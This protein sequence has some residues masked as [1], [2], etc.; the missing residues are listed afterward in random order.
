MAN[1]FNGNKELI[2]TIDFLNTEEEK[3][4]NQLLTEN[5]E[6]RFQIKQ[7]E[8]IGPKL[9]NELK[10]NARNAIL[11]S[12]LLIGLYITIRFDSFYALGSLV[13]LLHDVFIILSIFSLFNFEIS[14]AIIA[15]FLTI[16]GYSLNDTIVI[17]DRIRENFLKYPKKE[18]NILVNQ[19]LNETLSRTI[20][21]SLTTLIV[22]VVLYIWG[23]EVLQPFALALI[24]GV[25]IGTYSSL[26]IASPVM[27]YLD[28]KYNIDIP[29][30]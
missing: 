4:L 10:N 9:G 6:D 5:F 3:I 12:L 22:V 11:A 25:M 17:Y 2:I 29:E 1:P 19:S 23:G 27:F 13:A 16:V 15:A 20:I 18:K 26:F 8:S 7:I 30:E 14:I 24:I 21:T 28:N